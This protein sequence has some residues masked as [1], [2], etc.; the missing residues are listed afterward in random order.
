M[1]FELLKTF[2][3]EGPLTVVV[4]GDCMQ[5]TIPRGA[6]LR[7]ENRRI[8]WPGDAV[9][10]KR[11]D[12][13]IVCHRFL[14]YLL[15]RRGW[16]VITRAENSKRA[17]MPVY[18]RHVLGKVTRVDDAPFSPGMKDRL[19]ALLFYLPAVMQQLVARLRACESPREPHA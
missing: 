8:Y 10:F 9:A 4:N 1:H 2:A 7:L 3:Q 6:R 15:T 14:G 11:G 17:D 5:R 12:D 16:C 18:A 13:Q 19:K